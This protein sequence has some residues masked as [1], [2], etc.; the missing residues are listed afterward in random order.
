[1]ETRRE[2]L[3]KTAIAGIS[4]IVASGAAPAFA[5]ER[6]EKNGVS[7]EEAWKVH[8]KCLIIDGHQDT[9]VRFFGNKENP[10]NWLKRNPAY[11]ADIPRM[12]EGGQQYVGFFLVEDSGATSLWTV[13]EFILQ[14]LDA[15]PDI[16]MKVLSSK[17]AVRAGKAGKVGV[18]MEIEGPAMWLQGNIDI[19]RLL[20][21][22]GV[23]S[24]HI[25]HGEGGSDPTFLQGTASTYGPCKPE[26]RVAQRKNAVGLTAFG[27][28]VVKTEN[29]LG[30]ITDLSH[31]NDKAF[32]DVIEL[33]TKPPIMSHTAVFSLRN[34]YRC[35]TDD[36]IRALAAKGG[37]MGIVL[38]PGFID[39]DPQKATIDRVVDHILY[40][41]D[42]VG[43]DTV[44]FGSDYDG[45]TEVPIV[46]DV[47][48]LVNLTRAMLARGLTEEEIKKFWGGNFLRILQKTI[49]K[50]AK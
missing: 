29:E 19:L 16:F 15:H 2:F 1:M 25:T 14:Q 10:E 6:A 31:T 32:F 33:S 24:V 40:V 8:R 27:R 30:M 7:L 45:F 13:T 44:G 47:S 37:V 49:D 42:L 3:K 20:Y 9:S 36:Q 35:L 18:L 38:V 5:K 23:R 26:D 46:P 17:D 48:Q 28:E 43:I 4:G 41:R 22:L 34:H 11:H 39:A 21:R 50:P 12:R